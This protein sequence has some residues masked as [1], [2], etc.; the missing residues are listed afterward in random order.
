MDWLAASDW[1]P[2]WLFSRQSGDPFPI[3]TRNINGASGT[4]MFFVKART[5]HFLMPRYI[6]SQSLKHPFPIFLHQLVVQ[7]DFTVVI[8]IFYHI[9]MVRRLF[10][11]LFISGAD[12]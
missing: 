4:Q 9:P 6:Q 1:Q 8:Q 12:R 3:A 7:V 2:R 11:R 10:S 5:L